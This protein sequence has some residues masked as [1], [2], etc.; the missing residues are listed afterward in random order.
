[1]KPT[2]I[3]KG[4]KKIE[5]EIVTVDDNVKI[6]IKVIEKEDANLYIGETRTELGQ[7]GVKKVT[8]IQK[9]E[10]GNPVGDPIVKEDVIKEMKPTIIYKGTKKIEGEIVT[11][12]DNVKIPIKVIEKE[13]ANLY[14]GETRTEK[15]QAGVKK[16][17]TIQKT[18]KGNPVGDP[19]VKEE[20]IKEMKPTVIYKGTKKKPEVNLSQNTFVYDKNSTDI[21]SMILNSIVLEDNSLYIGRQIIGEVPTTPGRHAITVRLLRRDGVTCDVNVD[22]TIV[23]NSITTPEISKP[24]SNE[25]NK[26]ND[27]IVDKDKDKVSNT[28]VN[29]VGKKSIVNTVVKSENKVVT[30]KNIASESAN[31]ASDEDVDKVDNVEVKESI[32][33]SKN[34]NNKNSSEEINVSEDKKS[35]NI[36]MYTGLGLVILLIVGSLIK[37]FKKNSNK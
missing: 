8:T 23:N 25:S 14:I 22:I 6:P 2:I 18:E 29:T 16:V 12:D 27:N 7:A 3:Y 34:N 15:G 37:I 21:E 19:I 31:I 13:D 24:N 17:T 4:T 28:I 10:K 30:N 20:V 26:S 36:L 33:D 11:V 1:M 35:N 5:G 9:T 32:N